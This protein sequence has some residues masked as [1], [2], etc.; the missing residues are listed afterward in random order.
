M[1]TFLM[2]SSFVSYDAVLCYQIQFNYY[3]YYIFLFFFFLFLHW[4]L[5][6]VF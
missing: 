2:I 5:Y 1:F 6:S 3:Y 4:V